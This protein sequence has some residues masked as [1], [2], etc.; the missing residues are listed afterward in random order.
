M[1]GVISIN[2]EIIRPV[3]NLIIA[4][5]RQIPHQQLF[6]FLNMLA[7]KLD[8]L[9]GGTP[10]IGQRSLPANDFRNHVGNE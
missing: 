4:I 7:A 8:V 6:A 1:P 10:H 2:D 5:A 3:D 9:V